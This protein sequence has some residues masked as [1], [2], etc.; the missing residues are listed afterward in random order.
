M[1]GEHGHNGNVFEDVI[2]D[3]GRSELTRI[4]AVSS[5]QQTISWMTSET[6][7][8]SDSLFV[9]S[10][11][12]STNMGGFDVS[13]LSA[14]EFEDD[15]DGWAPVEESP[16]DPVG[17]VLDPED[18]EEDMGPH[19]A[20]ERD[21][22]NADEQEELARGDQK[23]TYPH[24]E[25]PDHGEDDAHPAELYPTAQHELATEPSTDDAALANRTAIFR[26]AEE[27]AAPTDPNTPATEEFHPDTAAANQSQPRSEVVDQVETFQER[28]ARF[29]WTDEHTEKAYR[30]G[31]KKPTEIKPD[32]VPH[33]PAQEESGES[34][35]E[36]RSVDV[37]GPPEVASE[38][39]GEVASVV[40]NGLAVQAPEGTKEVKES[41]M[42]D[43][44]GFDK[45]GV[46]GRTSVEEVVSKVDAREE[47]QLEEEQHAEPPTKR[48][49]WLRKE[50]ERDPRPK[51]APRK[52]REIPD[53]IEPDIYGRGYR[54]L[55]GKHAEVRNAAEARMVMEKIRRSRFPAR[56]DEHVDYDLYGR[57]DPRIF[58]PG[59][60]IESRRQAR[61]ASKA[62]QQQAALIRKKGYLLLEPGDKRLQDKEVK[63]IRD[64][65]PP[66]PKK[67][68]EIEVSKK[69]EEEASMG[70]Q[71]E[72]MTGS[73]VQK[74]PVEPSEDSPN[75]VIPT[76]ENKQAASPVDDIG[77][78]EMKEEVEPVESKT[79]GL[80]SQTPTRTEV[81][82]GLASRLNMFEQR[83]QEALE[84]RNQRSSLLKQ[85]QNFNAMGT[86]R[87]VTGH[88]AKED[89]NLQTAASFDDADFFGSPRATVP[90][91]EPSISEDFG[92]E[93]RRL[94]SLEVPPGSELRK[95]V[96]VEDEE[97]DSY[98]EEEGRRDTFREEELDD[99][100][101]QENVDGVE[102]DEE[103]EEDEDEDEE[104]GEED[105]EEGEDGRVLVAA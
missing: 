32:E 39:Q 64:Y 21:I 87:L 9:P 33:A 63:L 35:V 103:D 59:S 46:D 48:E 74:V 7:R 104:E 57:A 89:Q 25:D 34:P 6:S 98:E 13:N 51:V 56:G 36:D 38:E 83:D 85:K 82:S 86:T 60:D 29:R 80:A 71:A 55:F 90:E 31:Q 16:H 99:D 84:W 67:L 69:T 72:D 20:S 97:G 62:K 2:E 23:D 40:E 79:S 102:Q 91:L 94:R 45:K 1:D 4:E 26:G 42:D 47:P 53:W 3:G 101:T 78:T 18:D 28:M 68:R 70:Q 44:E 66:A 19:Q 52:I 49:I 8:G 15:D 93:S 37:D 96:E 11:A 88:V 73:E 22:R 14:G 75:T 10:S 81:S 17:H 105:E 54:A 61:E 50:F 12:V 76:A 58:G 24:Q 5:G 92:A 77:E 95:D 41:P 43:P 65:I 27:N 100:G 30:P